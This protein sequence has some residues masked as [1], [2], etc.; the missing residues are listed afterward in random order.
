M[1]VFLTFFKDYNMIMFLTLTGHNKDVSKYLIE[2]E[3]SDF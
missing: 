2:N 3:F 1:V